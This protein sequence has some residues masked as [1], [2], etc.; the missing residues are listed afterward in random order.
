MAHLKEHLLRHASIKPFKC[1]FC[2]SETQKSYLRRKA[3]IDHIRAFHPDIG[4]PDAAAAKPENV[5]VIV[6]VST[7]GSN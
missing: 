4:D 6:E 3:L 7:T 1:S 2:P 5:N